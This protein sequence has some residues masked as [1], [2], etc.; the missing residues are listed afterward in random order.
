[1][2]REGGG[3]RIEIT[4]RYTFDAAHRLDWHPG[5]CRNLHGHTYH[6]E[7]TLSGH[8]NARGVVMEFGE[9]DAIVESNVLHELDHSF[10]NDILANPT[11]ELLAARISEALSTALPLLVKITL[12][13]SSRSSVTI[14]LVGDATN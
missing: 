4:R 14:S 3:Q 1:M 9:L 10:L 12:W 13:E 11:S 7:V 2:S 8:V 5:K 6:L